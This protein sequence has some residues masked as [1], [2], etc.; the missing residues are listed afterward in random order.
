[1]YMSHYTISL[2]FS[3]VS[4]RSLELCHVRLNILYS[5]ENLHPVHLEGHTLNDVLS[6][7]EPVELVETLTLS[8][9][10]SSRKAPTLLTL[11]LCYL[12]H[13]GYEENVSHHYWKKQGKGE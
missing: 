8:C 9:I 3:C 2:A 11:V 6:L 12:F 4:L 1:M 10:I 7:K 5:Q 13:S